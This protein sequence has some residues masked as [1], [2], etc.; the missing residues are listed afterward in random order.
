MAHVWILCS[1]FFAVLV[2][3]TSAQFILPAGAPPLGRVERYF[4]EQL[5]DA[6][7]ND[8]ATLEQLREVLFRQQR[9]IKIQFHINITADSIAN[10]SCSSVC[11]PSRWWWQRGPCEPAFCRRVH[12][13]V[14][15][16]DNISTAYDQW[17]LCSNLNVMWITHANVDEFIE[18]LANT[19]VPWCAHG[20][21]FLVFS[22]LLTDAFIT[23]VYTG[24]F[25]EEYT[26]DS[27]DVVKLHLLLKDLECQP[28]TFQL[29][30]AVG[31]FFTWVRIITASE[32]SSLIWYSMTFCML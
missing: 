29:I 28:Y 18:A 2:P 13:K 19:V 15:R 20:P 12:E 4:Y 27:E 6:L 16:Y 17:K 21:S 3:Q 30:N 26:F 22:G 9:P 32:Y 5:E 1:C 11:Q 31:Q 24:V 7:S 23:K 14:S 8:G 10:S 25:G